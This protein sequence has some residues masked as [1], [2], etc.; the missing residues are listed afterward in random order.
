MKIEVLENQAAV[1]KRA[2]DL[3]CE[4]CSEAALKDNRAGNGSA[5]SEAVNVALSGGTTPKLLYQNLA[6]EPWRGRLPWG[7]VRWFL[8]D[9]RTV[10]VDHADSNYRMVR[11]AMFDVVQVSENL[12]FPVPLIGVAQPEQAAMD[13]EQEILHA[14]TDKSSAGLPRFDLMLLGVGTDGHTASLFP[15]TEAL[16]PPAGKVVVANHVEKMKSWRITMTPAVILQARRVIVMVTGEDKAE[17]L[18]HVLEGPDD[19]PSYP[20]QIARDLESA[21]WLLDEAA[22]ISLERS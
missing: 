13:Y 5:P 7:Q 1:A 18:K 15:H 8:G 19:F 11:E 20:A 16:T 14:V 10:P 4:I 21:V 17:A 6:R 12:R 2:A 3:L 9:E 22:A